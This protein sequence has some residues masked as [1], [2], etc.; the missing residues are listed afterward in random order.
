[1]LGDHPPW[2]LTAC[3]TSRQV[4]LTSQDAQVLPSY[5]SYEDFT[6]KEEGSD[7]AGVLSPSIPCLLHLKCFKGI[8]TQQYGWDYCVFLKCQDLISVWDHHWGISL[9]L[10]LDL[11]GSVWSCPTTCSENTLGAPSQ[12]ALQSRWLCFNFFPTF[13]CEIH[14]SSHPPANIQY[15]NHAGSVLT[16]YMTQ[17]NCLSWKYKYS[18]NNR[19]EG[20]QSCFKFV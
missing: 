8:N 1:M 17:Q 5:L 15:F 14:P 19:T 18:N 6:S 9:E 2:V 16:R 10:I 12:P 4:P 11:L 20:T 13:H 3:S 7:P